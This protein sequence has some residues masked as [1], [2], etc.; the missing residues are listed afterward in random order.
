MLTRAHV[1]P[2]AL[3][4]PGTLLSAAIIAAFLL[5]IAAIL[6]LPEPVRGP[7]GERGPGLQTGE[8]SSTGPASAVAGPEPSAIEPG[9]E[10]PAALD[11]SSRVVLI[12]AEEWDALSL[13]SVQQALAALPSAVQARL[14]NPA[15]GAV[16][17]LVNSEGRTSS[18]YQPY[19]RAANFFSTNEGTNEVVL[20][21]QQSALTVLHELGH[22]YNLRYSPAGNYAGV[23]LDPE[24]QSFMAATGW[25]V[26]TPPAR[27]SEMSDHSRVEISYTGDAVWPSMSRNDPLEDFANSFAMYFLDPAGLAARSPERHAW[28]AARFGP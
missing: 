5:A 28:F 19:G 7:S 9:L 21:P 17:V 25:Q 2:R 23:L 11:T 4:T 27:I 3:P 14:G 10:A 12:G 8:V 24:M 18:G 1:P 22:A 20:Y 13:A 16:K 26:L 15:Y 6:L